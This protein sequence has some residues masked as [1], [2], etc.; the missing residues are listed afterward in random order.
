MTP[1][2]FAAHFEKFEYG[3]HAEVQPPNAFLESRCGDCDDYA[4]LADF[5][6]KRRNFDTRL[7]RVSLVGRVAHDVCYVVSSQAY[8]DCNNRKYS[9]TLEGASRR[10]RAIAK[11]V[12]DSFEAN[13]TSASEYTYDYDTDRKR[14][15]LTVVKT[16]LAARDPDV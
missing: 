6:L 5:V 2:R 10:L 13:W 16:D 7:V 8:L 12:A 15:G 1:K 11:E 4:I 9:A 14:L 3:F